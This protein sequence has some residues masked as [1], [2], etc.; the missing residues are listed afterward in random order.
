MT[1]HNRH[2]THEYYTDIDR[3]WCPKTE[4]YTG[5]DSLLT[6]Q[7]N[8]WKLVG[9]AYREDIIFGG[10]RHTTLYHFE[11]ARADETV[12]MPVISNPFVVRM[13]QT[14]QIDVL[15]RKQEKLESSVDSLVQLA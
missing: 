10:G 2:S 11:L 3:H 4:S 6:A 5:A 8:G 12:Y 14:R 13:L 1:I 9:L 7:R 15:P